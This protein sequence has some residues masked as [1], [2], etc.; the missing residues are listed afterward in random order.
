VNTGSNTTS[1]GPRDLNVLVRSRGRFMTVMLPAL[2]IVYVA[3]PLAAA[4]K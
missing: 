1:Q 3:V 2:L 4:R